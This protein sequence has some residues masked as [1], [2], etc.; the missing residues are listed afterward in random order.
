MTKV[1]V[2]TMIQEELK[3]S[4]GKH[5]I[6]INLRETDSQRTVREAAEKQREVRLKEERKQGKT[7][8]KETARSFQDLCGFD[9][10]QARKAAKAEIRRSVNR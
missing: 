7:M 10:K 6:Q 4:L 2:E 1:E 8:L 3:R 9:K 5:G